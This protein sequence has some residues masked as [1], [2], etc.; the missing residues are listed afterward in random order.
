MHL[1]VSAALALCV[2]L[3]V[4]TKSVAS[5]KSTPASVRT[6]GNVL[7]IGAVGSKSQKY[8]YDGLIEAMANNGFN[9]GK[10]TS[11]LHA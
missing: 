11:F 10:H 4:W 6:T 5:A 9:V 3:V 7:F 2:C 1:R 8:F